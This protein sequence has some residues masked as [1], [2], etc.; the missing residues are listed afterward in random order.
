[1]SRDLPWGRIGYA[2]FG[3]LAAV[4]IAVTATMF[5]MLLPTV[6][7]DDGAWGS[8]YATSRSLGDI[9]PFALMITF[10]TALPGFLL[11]L[12]V[13]R[14][15]GW[16]GWLPFA[17]AGTLD[18]ILALVIL[19]ISLVQNRPFETPLQILLPCLPGGFA[20]GFAYWAVVRRSLLSKEEIVSP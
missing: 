9:F 19:N 12:F 5:A 17:C 3:Y 20:G 13:A 10:L 16:V 14:R 2:F 7:P 15:R 6:L 4:L 8:Y 11:T 18:A 1:M